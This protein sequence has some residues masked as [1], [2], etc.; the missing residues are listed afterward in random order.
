[1]AGHPVVGIRFPFRSGLIIDYSLPALC[2]V[3]VHTKKPYF[4]ALFIKKKA[5]E[6]HIS[7]YW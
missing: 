7:G 1:L 2:S 6:Q 3:F 5:A 4:F